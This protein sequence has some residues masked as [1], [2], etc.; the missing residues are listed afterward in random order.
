MDLG[1]RFQIRETL[2]S[3]VEMSAQVLEALGLSKHEAGDTARRFR[4]HDAAMML[5]Q[6]AVKDDE[7]K[8]I[9][10]SQESARQLEHLFESDDAEDRSARTRAAAG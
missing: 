4:D 6:Y 8:L 3:S 2:L 1:V 7:K 5:R 9:E 10:S